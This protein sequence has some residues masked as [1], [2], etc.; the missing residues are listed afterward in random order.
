[1]S[2]VCII[3]IYIFEYGINIIF[4]YLLDSFVTICSMQK[5]GASLEHVVNISINFPSE[6]K[7]IIYNI[8]VLIN[9]PLYETRFAIQCT[10]L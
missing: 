7:L 9:A 2:S 5:L 1:M 8:S 3:L 4:C 6:S 10:Q